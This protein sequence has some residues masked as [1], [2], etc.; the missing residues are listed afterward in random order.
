MKTIRLALALALLFSFC[1]ALWPSRRIGR[2]PVKLIAVFPAG[3]EDQVARIPRAQ[4][5]ADWGSR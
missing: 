3:I 2:P 1:A 5:G 4:L